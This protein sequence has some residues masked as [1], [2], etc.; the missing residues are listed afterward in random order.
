MQV[1]SLEDYCSIL[2]LSYSPSSG[3]LG[4]PDLLLSHLTITLALHNTIILII[5]PTSF[6]LSIFLSFCLS[7]PKS[8]LNRLTQP[9]KDIQAAILLALN[10][11]IQELKKSVPAAGL[12]QN[13]LTLNNGLFSHFDTRIRKQLE[14]VWHTLS[15]RTVQVS[16]L[17]YSLIGLWGCFSI[18]VACCFI[19]SGALE[20]VFFYYSL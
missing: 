18:L 12:D 19:W 10:G 15:K 17:G 5:T 14:P 9:M 20:L 11:S 13:D 8:T 4:S 1:L 3:A 16:L 7:T 2:L 6:Y